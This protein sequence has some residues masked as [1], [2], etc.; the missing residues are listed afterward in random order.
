MLRLH[1][2]EVYDQ[3]VNHEI[4]FNDPKVVEVAD[5]VGE[6]VKNPDYLGGDTWSRRSPPPS[7]RTAA[8]RS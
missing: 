1:G 3:W 7:S 8:C 5:A 2:E 6:Y 4:P